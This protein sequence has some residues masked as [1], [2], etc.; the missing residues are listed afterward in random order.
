LRTT[1]LE[2]ISLTY[3]SSFSENRKTN[4]FQ[5]I[6]KIILCPLSHEICNEKIANIDWNNLLK[7]NIK[8][9]KFEY[10]I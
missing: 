7:E 4:F 5:E 3:F 1:D 8:G 6:N 9:T 10:I 2:K